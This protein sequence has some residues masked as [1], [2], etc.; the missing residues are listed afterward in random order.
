MQIRETQWEHTQNYLKYGERSEF[1][2][3]EHNAQGATGVTGFASHICANVSVDDNWNWMFCVLWW[4]SCAI[5]N[6]V[7]VQQVVNCRSI[8]RTGQSLQKISLLFFWLNKKFLFLSHPKIR[9]KILHPARRH[10][11][12][13]EWRNTHT[14]GIILPFYLICCGVQRASKRVQT[15]LSIKK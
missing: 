15:L 11:A 9:A 4:R 13:S 7:T 6:C 3:A 1:A 12:A 10:V 5:V 2:R 14:I 8:S